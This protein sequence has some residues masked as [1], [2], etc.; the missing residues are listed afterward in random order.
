M[1]IVKAT[2][3]RALA[4]LK[5]IDWA[6]QDALTDADIERQVAGN[7]DA[8][9]IL[10]DKESAA[11]M[12]LALRAR[13]KLSQPAFAARYGIP[14]GTVRDWEQ[15]RRQPD[16]AALSYLRVIFREP[17]VT[18]RALAAPAAE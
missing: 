16:Q 15:Q 1:A 10:T 18:A 5:A 12:L 11:G 2:K 4:A 14:V 3:A 8:G 6:A 13:L 9:A 7:P 17:E